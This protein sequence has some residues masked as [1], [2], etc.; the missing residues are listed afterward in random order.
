MVPRNAGSGMFADGAIELTL[1]SS[2]STADEPAD[3]A[4]EETG[5][6]GTVEFAAATEVEVESPSEVEPTPAQESLLAAT[7]DQLAEPITE[8]D[9]VE[10]Q[11]TPDLP[12]EIAA[13]SP[14]T[15]S[16]SQPRLALVPRGSPRMRIEPGVAA[17]PNRFAGIQQAL[18]RGAAQTQVFG[19]TGN[20]HKFV[21]VFDRSG[22]M[23]G[24]GGI[25][26]L[27]AKRELIG[28]LRQLGPTH[29]FQIVFYNQQPRVFNLT[30][31]EGRLAFGTDQN[32]VLAERF[33]GG[34]TA[35]GATQHEEPLSV[36]LRLVPD[37]IFLLTDGDEPALS[38]R[39]MDRLARLNRGSVINTIEF[40]YGPNDGDDN[41]LARLARSTG[42][43]YAYVDVGDLPSYMAERN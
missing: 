24:H 34:M 35:D 3:E 23:D 10:R 41:F 19:T 37:V 31:D 26:M 42:G 40:G 36:A 39:Q 20:G 1:T 7:D 29:Q 17:S 32:K 8:A 5:E 16:A 27:A 30:G 43:Q 12:A 2:Q 38:A 13:S 33:I 22:S 11:P 28:S 18:A 9:L 25:P 21:Y 6:S 4:A 15:S 14:E